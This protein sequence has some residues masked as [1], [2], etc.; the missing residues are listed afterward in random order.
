MKRGI[1]SIAKKR[2]D[3]IYFELGVIKKYPFVSSTMK[4]LELL[5]QF[6]KN[7]PQQNPDTLP[8]DFT[9]QIE[10]QFIADPTILLADD[11]ILNYASRFVTQLRDMYQDE[12]QQTLDRL[13]QNS[14]SKET[15]ELLL[16]LDKHVIR[17][18]RKGL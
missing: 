17:M 15:Q 14:W 7:N 4:F 6:L 13:V 5:N 10:K 9:K 18:P 1:E 12:L 3:E 16:K 8:E 11:R 2:H